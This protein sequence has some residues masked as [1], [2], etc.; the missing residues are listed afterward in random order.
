M[1]NF[2]ND[3]FDYCYKDELKSD[4]FLAYPKDEQEQMV[5]KA[6]ARIVADVERLTKQINDKDPKIALNGTFHPSNRYY[7][8]LFKIIT[9]I[10]LPNGSNDTREAV[11]KWVGQDKIDALNKAKEDE[12][13]AERAIEAQ[14]EQEYINKLKEKVI[15]D[16]SITGDELVDVA[17]SLNIEI[18]PRTVGMLRNRVRGITSSQ[19]RI[20]GKSTGNSPWEIYKQVKNAIVA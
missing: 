9:G 1:E 12:K 20:T 16:E 10:E 18:H 6:K 13:A 8:K 19:A 7:R 11:I 14:K 2:I 5:I 17:R 4:R 3:F 15:K